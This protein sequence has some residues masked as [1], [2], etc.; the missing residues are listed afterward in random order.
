MEKVMALAQA[1]IEKLRQ[2]NQNLK[3][4]SQTLRYE[5]KQVLGK[6]FKPRIKPNLEPTGRSR[7]S[8][9]LGEASSLDSPRVKGIIY[10]QVEAD[11]KSSCH[12]TVLF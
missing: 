8:T 11:Q 3:E 10:N 7:V 5:L 12:L 4:E 6:I 2:E 1:E 9:S